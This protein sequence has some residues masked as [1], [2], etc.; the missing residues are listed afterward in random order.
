M[1]NEGRPS[2][3]QKTE[4]ANATPAPN[5]VVSIL[6]G[7]LSSVNQIKHDIEGIKLDV[8]RMNS[9]ITNIK[10]YTEVCSIVYSLN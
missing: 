9:E 1:E 10:R 8:H 6:Q 4:Q 7:I 3:K 5:D 2:K